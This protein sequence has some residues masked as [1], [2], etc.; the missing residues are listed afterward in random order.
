[1]SR[2]V[3][4]IL[5]A[6]VAA[7]ANGDQSAGIKDFPRR[8]VYFYRGIYCTVSCGNANICN[9]STY[10][11]QGIVLECKYLL[12][13]PNLSPYFSYTGFQLLFP[14]SNL[15]RAF[16]RGQKNAVN[17]KKSLGLHLVRGDQKLSSL[18]FYFDRLFIGRRLSF[19]GID[20]DG[21]CPVGDRAE[22]GF[23]S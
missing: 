1:L 17:R 8:F 11:T 5:T 12:R 18:E 3:A 14:K 9:N 16:V 4:E 10:I 6:A 19:S 7:D 15:Y 2:I 22:L 13:V 23:A 21:G 20:D